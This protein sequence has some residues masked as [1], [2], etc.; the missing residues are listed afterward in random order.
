MMSRH[1]EAL[2]GL[3]R[4]F[5][6][7]VPRAVGAFV[8]G[9]GADD[10]W[11]AII[12]RAAPAE[13][14]TAAGPRLGDEDAADLRDRAVDDLRRAADVGADIRGP[15]DDDWPADALA[16][17]DWVVPYDKC[18]QAWRPL[19]LYR[20]GGRW[21]SRSAGVVA[22]VGSRAATPYGVRTACE[23]ASDAARDGAC[24]ISGAAFGIDA[25]AH[26]GALQRTWGDTAPTVAVLAGGVDR[27]YP[28]AHRALI[29][30][31]A[32]VGAVVSEYAPGAAP[33][34][35]RFLVR[36]R[37]IAAFAEI[38]VVVEAGRRSGSLNTAATAA[39]LGRTVAAVPGPVTSAMSVGCHDLLRNGRADLVTAW[40][41]V[42]AL[43]G[44]MRVDDA[45]HRP[46]ER[47]T[48]GLDLVAARVHEAL[49]SRGSATLEAIAREAALPAPDVLG[50]LAALHA[51]GL[52][53]RTESG[54][55]R[56]RP[57]DAGGRG[58]AA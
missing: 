47:A 40:A 46:G 2:A 7:P 31:V 51:D 50:A 19:A 9:V 13:V 21:P 52:A 6:P 16:P 45:P 14:L 44:P 39:G 42:R 24:I 22:I 30:D 57:L 55:A 28:V 26:R 43:M 33:A 5:E 25:A 29:E 27:P 4:L 10:A 3:L 48:D 15:G 35:H 56:A 36:N 18:R 23:I 17:L 32:E 20:R 53:R 12:A 11:S 1:R 34:R 8:D 54:W 58:R 37:L 41:D 49:P 38:T